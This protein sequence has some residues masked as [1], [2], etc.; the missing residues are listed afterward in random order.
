MIYEIFTENI[1]YYKIECE[2]PTKTEAEYSIS[3]V[4]NY[5]LKIQQK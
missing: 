1:S 4:K 2:F 5:R 3:D